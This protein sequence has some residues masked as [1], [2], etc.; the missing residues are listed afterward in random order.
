MKILFWTSALLV[1]YTYFGYPL[2]LWA[3]TERRPL[4]VRRKAIFPRV[5]III[6]ARN[7]ADKIGRKIEHTLALDYPDERREVLVASDA[8]DDATDEIVHAYAG[9]GVF[10]A[11]RF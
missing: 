6:A 4:N 5:S 1:A 10:L 3:L 7:E 8:S 9:R 11:R 2:V